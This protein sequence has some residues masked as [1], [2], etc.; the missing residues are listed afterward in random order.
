MWKHFWYWW[1]HTNDK[2]PK[3]E[4]MTWGGGVRLKKGLHIWKHFMSQPS[5][6]WRATPGPWQLIANCEYT[7]LSWTYIH[8]EA[9]PSNSWVYGEQA[10]KDIH[11]APFLFYPTKEYQTDPSN[12]LVFRC[13]IYFFP[14][15]SNDK[16]T[17]RPRCSFAMQTHK[18]CNDVSG[19][20]YTKVVFY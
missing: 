12:K 7:L 15:P 13:Y 3:V 2:V 19:C 10:Y 4:I 17:L 9:N 6:N 14:S 5:P 16:V 1:H 18:C 20:C 8:S 11:N